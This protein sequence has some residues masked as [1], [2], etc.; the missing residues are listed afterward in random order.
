MTDSSLQGATVLVTGGHGFL[1][2]AVLRELARVGAHAVA[3]THADVEFRD[4]TAVSRGF[5]SVC[6]DVVIH[7]AARVG[8]IGANQLHPGTFWRDNLLMGVNV[9]EAARVANVKR[10]VIVG[11]VCAYPKF[12]PVPFRESALWEGYPE[13]TNAPYGVAKRALWTG[14]DAYHREFGLAGAYLLPANMYGPDD[15]FDLETSHV[16]P[17][18]IRKFDDAVRTGAREVSLWGTG[19]PTREFL[20]VDDCAEAL[21]IAA[22]TIDDPEP[23][24][25]GTGQEIRMDALAL[26]VAAATGFEGAVRWDASRPDG[27]PR[28]ALDTSRAR[29]RLGWSARTDLTTGLART[30]AWF[31]Q[32]GTSARGV[33]VPSASGAVR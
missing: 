8:G 27:Q 3:P 11:T 29:E 20:Y 14:L 5:S 12:T 22:A 28:R 7:L 26:R 9:L 30:V 2:K 33:G 6:P 19:A 4:P 1:G 23:M 17:A 10:V 32:A 18:M 24:N 31:R 21:V 13:E 25:V 16:I 15:D